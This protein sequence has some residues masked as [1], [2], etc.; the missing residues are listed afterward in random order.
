MNCLNFCVCDKCSSR[1]AMEHRAADERFGR[2]WENGGGCA[3]AACRLT[4]ENLADIDARFK[5]IADLQKRL[6]RIRA[7]GTGD[8]AGRDPPMFSTTGGKP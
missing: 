2:D 6:N 5:R 3:C 4:R 1:I 8:D 7:L